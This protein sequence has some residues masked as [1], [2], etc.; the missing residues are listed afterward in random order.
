MHINYTMEAAEMQINAKKPRHPAIIYLGEYRAKQKRIAALKEELEN[1][2]EM[3][4]N[5]SVRA[6]A[7]RVTGSKE[8]D[9]LA[10]HAV[11]AVDVQRRLDTTILHLQECLDM[12]LFLI[13]QIDTGDAQEDENEKLV[14]TYRYINCLPWEQIQYKMHYGATAVFELHGRALQ[15][16]WKVYQM[17]Q[18]NGV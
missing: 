9:T 6:D 12:R 13:E 17:M 10:N 15:S 14:L 3:A 1:I 18:K 16:F 4:T 8:R 5:V 11:H 7:D 2:R